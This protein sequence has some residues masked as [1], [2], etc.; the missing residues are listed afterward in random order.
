MICLHIPEVERNTD[1]GGWAS[2]SH[3]MYVRYPKIIY[4]I[5]DAVYEL[6]ERNPE[7]KHL[8]FHY[9][10]VLLANGIAWSDSSMKNAA[11]SKRDA[12]CI[13]ALFVGIACAERFAEGT[14]GRFF[15]DGTAL[16][17]LKRLDELDTI[18]L[19]EKDL[20]F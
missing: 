14:I 6:I 5:L 20:H 10:Q 12:Q 11:V 3:A 13:L 19:H 1:W 17:W 4:Q 15:A 18:Q 7:F 16:R 2:G 8:P 9:T